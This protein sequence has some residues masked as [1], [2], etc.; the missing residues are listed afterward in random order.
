MISLRNALCLDL[1][2][3]KMEMASSCLRVLVYV[4]FHT[5][6]L[7]R[8]SDILFC[9]LVVELSISFRLGPFSRLILIYLGFLYSVCS[10]SLIFPMLLVCKRCCLV[11]MVGSFITS[12][13]SS[14]S[15]IVVCGGC[16]M[17]TSSAVASPVNDR[18][19]IWC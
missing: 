10:I 15:W 17:L 13:S 2:S 3:V 12:R 14:M 16:A 9:M 5:C 4:V 18:G 8:F 6:S 11:S 1:M 7:S 19:S